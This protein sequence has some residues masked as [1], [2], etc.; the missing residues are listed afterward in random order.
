[1]STEGEVWK[2]IP[3]FSG[4]YEA[5]NLGRIRGVERRVRRGS[6]WLAIPETILSPAVRASGHLMVSLS[7]GD[8]QR[9]VDVHKLV[10][11][12]FV[13]EPPHLTEVRHLDGN[14][15]NNHLSNLRYG[16]RSENLHDA[17]R[18]GTHHWAKRTHCKNGH[19]YTPDN[20]MPRSSGSGRQ[21]RECMLQYKRRWNSKQSGRVRE[22]VEP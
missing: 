13:G 7:R 15:A 22:V 6:G 5:S 9:S 14:H 18:H 11:L 8:S 17:V 12:A 10:M 2:A 3:G 16:T 4:D 20:T 19:E 21:C 1:M